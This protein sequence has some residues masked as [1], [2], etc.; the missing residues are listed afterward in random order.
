MRTRRWTRPRALGGP[1]AGVA[2][3]RHA[4]RD[5]AP[6]RRGSQATV[7]VIVREV[8]PAYELVCQ[9]RDPRMKGELA[10]WLWR[11]GALEQQPTDLAEPYAMEISG[12]WRGAARAWKDRWAAPMSRP[13]C[14]PCTESEAEQREALTIFELLG[15]APAAQALRK[16]MRAQGARGRSARLPGIHP[17]Q[18]AR[19]HEARGRDSRAVV[20]GTA[21]FGHR[22][23][24]IS[25][26]PKRSTTTSRRY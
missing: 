12:D 1:G 6:R 18:S 24:P 21:Q 7:R 11:V 9:R 14:S 8:Q 4:C 10:A 19:P 13:R 3:H 5:L 16:D 26:P 22:E 17:E 25:Y 23:A 15:A 20:G 2:A